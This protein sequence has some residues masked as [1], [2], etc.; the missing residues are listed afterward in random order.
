MSFYIV[1]KE[2]VTLQ[3]YHVTEKLHMIYVKNGKTDFIQPTAL[4][5]RLQYRNHLKSKL[6][7]TIQ[8]YFSSGQY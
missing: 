8:E 7:K 3:V 6:R 5:E 2:N 1:Q 4:G